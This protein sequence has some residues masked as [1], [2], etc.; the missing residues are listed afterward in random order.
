MVVVPSAQAGVTLSIPVYLVIDIETADAPDE[1]IQA[2][3]DRLRE[4]ARNYKPATIEKSKTIA[5]SW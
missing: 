2:E 4:S 5:P 3:Q 1:A